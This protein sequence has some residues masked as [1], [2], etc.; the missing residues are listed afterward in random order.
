MSFNYEN[1]ETKRLYLLTDEFINTLDSPTQFENAVPFDSKNYSY[2]TTNLKPRIE[3]AELT[4]ESLKNI[5][6]IAENYR[7]AREEKPAP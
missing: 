4:E 6:K 7:L 3:P 5:K 1:G 2:N